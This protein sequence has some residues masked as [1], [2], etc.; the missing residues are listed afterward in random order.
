MNIY[1][2]GCP[3]AQEAGAPQPCELERGGGGREHFNSLVIFFFQV[4]LK[5]EEP[6]LPE[7]T[8]LTQYHIK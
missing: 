6:D 5:L 2:A 4:V 8:Q 7:D 3:I 1:F